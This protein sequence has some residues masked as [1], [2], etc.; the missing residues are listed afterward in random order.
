MNLV[1]EL[2]N[3]KLKKKFLLKNLPIISR[4]YRPF[5]TEQ[6]SM[7]KYIFQIYL[8]LKLSSNILNIIFYDNL[9]INHQAV[10]KD[11]YLNLNQIHE[12]KNKGMIFGN[13]TFNHYPLTK[14]NSKQQFNEIKRNH[15]FLKKHDLLNLNILAYPYGVYNKT[16]IKIL[17]KL[18]YNFAFS[19][20]QSKSSIKNPF[21]ISRVDANYL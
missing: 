5:D 2:L 6:I 21:E 7:F 8:P 13:H 15:D 20:K 1:E 18:K 3:K 9:K 19:V 16:T 12:M 4:K 11:L 10:F 14:L 17:K